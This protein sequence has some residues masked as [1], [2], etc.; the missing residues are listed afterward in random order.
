[1]YTILICLSKVGMVTRVRITIFFMYCETMNEEM[2]KT[3]YDSLQTNKKYSYST[4]GYK[5]KIK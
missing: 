2:D 5:W 4:V 3:C 1:M